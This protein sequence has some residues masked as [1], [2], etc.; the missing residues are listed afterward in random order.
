M[1]A[2]ATETTVKTGYAKVTN[3]IGERLYQIVLRHRRD[4]DV[5]KEEEDSWMPVAEGETTPQMTFTY[6]NGSGSPYDYWWIKITT[7]SG[8][9]YTCK[10]DF[11]CSV[12][13]A[14]D[15]NVTLVVDGASMQ[16]SVSFSTSTGCTVGLRVV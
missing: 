14:D 7:T 3:N 6:E 2:E 9:V 16:M 12:G 5:T 1:S 4:N 11:Y 10:S 8:R 13:A 15:G